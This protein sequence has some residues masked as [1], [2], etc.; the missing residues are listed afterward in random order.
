MG[1]N[2]IISQFFA[3]EGIDEEILTR[4]R[5]LRIAVLRGGT[6]PER[7][8][9]LMSGKA[10]YDALIRRGYSAEEYDLTK[11]F[12]EGAL[13]RKFDAVFIALHGAP[14]EDGS[15]QGF[16][17]IVGIPYVGSGV[18]AS[19][20]ALDK[21]WTKA[22]FNSNN[23]KTTNFIS[24]CLENKHTSIRLPFDAADTDLVKKL[25]ELAKDPYNY[26]M[27]F[28][29]VVKP[30]HL[31]SSVGVTIAKS[32]GDILEAI[33]TI[34]GLDCCVII[35]EYIKGRE[36]QCGVIGRNRPIP[37]PLIEIRTEREF[38]DYTAKY[39]PGEAEE[40]SPAPISKELTEIA[41][42]IAVKAF[43]ALGCRDFARVDMFLTD[44][45]EYIVNEVNT[46]PGLTPYSLVPKEAAAAGISYDELIEMIIL[47]ALKE[48]LLKK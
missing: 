12:F 24:F 37:L 14:G 3:E 28:P 33:E 7:E 32:H 31:G 8:V 26:N 13:N 20:A 30:S 2:E 48:S 10:V 46:I 29:V 1:K 43:K 34:K 22:I 47:P 41:Q 44:N 5:Q 38:F 40:I 6:S 18:A 25:I 4:S 45:E 39:T 17:D 16:L 42:T 23:L 19:A 21:L 9:S 11:E 15:V 35:E 27:K 36:I